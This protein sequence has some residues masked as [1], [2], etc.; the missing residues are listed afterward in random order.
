MPEGIAQGQ[1]DAPANILQQLLKI[2]RKIFPG[3]D[4]LRFLTQVSK[5]RRTNDQENVF[6][7]GEI[8]EYQQYPDHHLTQYKNKAQEATAL[9]HQPAVD[10]QCMTQVSNCG[11]GRSPEKDH[12]GYKQQGIQDARNYDPFPQPVFGNEPVSPEIGLNSYNDFFQQV[13]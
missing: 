7:Q 12:T 10:A 6:K 2:K 4:R 5:Q 8:K 3:K 1:F 11:A 9:A 13:L